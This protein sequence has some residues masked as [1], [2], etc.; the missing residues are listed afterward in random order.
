M[1]GIV[2]FS[3]RSESWGEKLTPSWSAGDTLRVRF[4]RPVNVRPDWPLQGERAFVDNGL[5]IKW[6]RKGDY[7]SNNGEYNHR[8]NAVLRKGHQ[9]V[10]AVAVGAVIQG[11][12]DDKERTDALNETHHVDLA[13]LEGDDATGGDCCCTASSIRWCGRL[14]CR[15]TRQR[16]SR[17]SRTARWPSRT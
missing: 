3:Y 10:S 11:D 5:S 16:S 17:T 15:A 2:Q 6:D 1:P 12:K 4:D 14:R 13:E 9:M 8:H 7:L